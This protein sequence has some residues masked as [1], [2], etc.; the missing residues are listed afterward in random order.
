MVGGAACPGDAG[1]CGAPVP[2][3]ARATVAFPAA[4][5]YPAAPIDT[6]RFYYEYE[7]HGYLSNFYASPVVVDGVEWPTTEH[8]YQA[9]KTLDPAYAERIRQAATADEAKRLGNDAACPLRADWADARIDAMRRAL[10]AKFAQHGDLREQ[11]LATGDA[12]LLED[13]KKDA[14]WGAGPDGSGLSMLGRLLMELRG[15]L[16]AQ[17][18]GPSGR[19][20]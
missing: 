8:Y 15:R 20:A 3:G 11:L 4:K 1:T 13:S 6:I 10:A 7:A 16:R 5:R 2:R 18:Q 9:C 14:F 12:V 17:P 19:R